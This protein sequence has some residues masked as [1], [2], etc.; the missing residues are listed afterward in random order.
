[1]DE[2]KV[3]REWS[4]SMASIALGSIP[5]LFGVWPPGP[6]KPFAV[7]WPTSI[8][9][10]LV[11][12]EVRL[13]DHLE[14]VEET[15]PGMF[16]EAAVPAVEIPEGPDSSETVLLPL[17]MVLGARSGDK[18]GNANLGVF[19]R[20]DAAHGWMHRFLTVDRLK[21]LLP[22]MRGHHIERFDLPNLRAVNFVIHGLL[23]QGVSSSMRVDPQAKGLGEYLRA[24]LVD[25][26][27][28]LIEH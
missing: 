15:E 12:S 9:R 27:L 6:A 24:Q 25:L 22:D 4:N 16:H 28:A 8:P 18:G 7:Y 13:G 5:G 10:D 20:S 3:G 21:S 2:R 14:T 1:M 11:R 19:A 17:G 26:P 23:D